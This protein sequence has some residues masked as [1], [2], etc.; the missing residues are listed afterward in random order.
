M[1]TSA[2][3]ETFQRDIEERFQRGLRRKKEGKMHV[4][5]YNLIDVI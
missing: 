3:Q 5:W 2:I 1:R 4:C